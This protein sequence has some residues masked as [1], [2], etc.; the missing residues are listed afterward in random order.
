MIFKIHMRTI[1]RRT[2]CAAALLALLFT[3]G[4]AAYAD[5]DTTAPNVT[6]GQYNTY[7]TSANSQET[8]LTPS[9]VSSGFGYLFQL[10]PQ[11]GLLYAQPLILHNFTISGTCHA[12]VVFLATMKNKIVAY[13]G[14][15]PSSTPLWQSQTFGTA[16]TT[17]SVSYPAL[18]CRS[19]V[20]FTSVGILS[21]PVIDAKNDL[22]YFVTLNDVAKATACTAGGSTKW[23]YTL[24]AMSL[25][26]DSTFGL[27]YIPPHDIDQDIE[28]Y[29]FVA[30]QQLQRPAL[31]DAN[32]SIFIGFGFGTSTDGGGEIESN[33]QGWMAQYNSCATGSASCPTTTCVTNTNCSFF[34]AS[35]SNPG[36]LSTHGAGVWSSGIG[37]AT[38]GTYYA[39]STGNGCRPYQETTPKNCAP[40]TDNLLGDS[41]IYR[42]TS[43]IN[44]NLGTTFT[45]ENTSESSGFM[46][47]YVD[48]YNDLDVSSG[49]VMMIP[50]AVPKATASY[51]VASGKAGQTYLLQ[52][53][54]LGGYTS[55]P[56]QSFFGAVSTAPC[57]VPFPV[58]PQTPLYGGIVPTGG[59]CAEIHNPAYWTLSSDTGFY[60]VW[61]FGDVLRG[62]FFNGAKFETAANSSTP[63]L[64]GTTAAQGG[65][66]LAVSSNGMNESTA[67][68]WGVTSDGFASSGAFLQGALTAH[69]LYSGSGAYE[70]AGIYNSKTQTGET[71]HAQRYVVP[72]VNNGKVYVSAVVNGS[73]SIFVY[74]PCSQGPNGVCGTQP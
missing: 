65:G 21:T 50:P 64:A 39:F 25:K 7:R 74:G 46:N 15:T 58:Y 5:C 53:S 62:Y 66:A 73:G 29:G 44:T 49:G 40:I 20:G 54:N 45:P 63:P 59:G 18:Y 48:D 38:D 36:P 4:L 34:Y 43:T 23:E 57:A 68:L 16:P 47:Y 61:G 13:D 51:L 31:F 24:H 17:G 32:G 67:I 19:N 60:F 26:N 33:Y 52:T 30:T 69:Q 37:P 6:G 14:D 35:A 12:T 71:F 70:I 56:Y 1:M 22:M 42:P 27:D 55:T 9:T 8:T 3:F 11:A 72:L 2:L 41:V 10:A 28:Q